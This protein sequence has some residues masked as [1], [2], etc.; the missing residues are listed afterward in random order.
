QISLWR[1]RCY[2]GS[3]LLPFDPDA[4]PWRSCSRP[5]GLT[6]RSQVEA[7]FVLWV[8]PAPLAR[9]EQ[10]MGFVEPPA[11]TDAEVDRLRVLRP[12]Q[13]RQ[14]PLIVAAAIE[15]DGPEIASVRAHL[16]VLGL[17]EAH[18]NPGVVLQDGGGVRKQ[19]LARHR[20]AVVVHEVHGAL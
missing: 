15:R 7:D 6:Q 12:K 14:L 4:L 19:E 10:E 9:S 13:I 8:C 18:R 11:I 20:E 3:L 1:W 2:H 5:T 17:E 16:P